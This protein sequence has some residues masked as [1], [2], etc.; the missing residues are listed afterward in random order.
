MD[1]GGWRATVQEVAKSRTCLS[2]LNVHTHTLVSGR[3]GHPQFCPLTPGA[4][5]SW[6]CRNR[7]P[8]F[9][10]SSLFR[11]ALKA[12]STNVLIN[13]FELLN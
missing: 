9:T 4:I 12:I 7:E 2:D 11:L 3:A 8:Q 1:R 6:E 13:Q 5:A 10:R